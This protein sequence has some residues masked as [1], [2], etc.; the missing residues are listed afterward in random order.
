MAASSLPAG[1]RTAE[2]TPW[3]AVLRVLADGSAVGAGA[4]SYGYA[5]QG[6]AVSAAAGASGLRMLTAPGT[7]ITGVVSGGIGWQSSAVVT[8]DG[9][10]F[11]AGTAAYGGS[12]S[13]YLVEKALPAG[14]TAAAVVVR[15]LRM[16]VIM[17]DGS[18][19]ALGAN[20]SSAQGT[21]N[22]NNPGATLTPVVLPA[23]SVATDVEM[24]N[25]TTLFLLQSGAV[26][27]AGLN[28][29]GGAG[30]GTTGGAISTPVRVPLAHTATQIT[31]SWY[32]S[33]LAVL[34]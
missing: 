18:V 16:M 7:P 34:G 15:Q 32:D 27:F 26:Y 30:A 31:V 1:V 23:G 24:G 17:T 13:F 11:T 19:Y 2:V 10:L 12:G 25:D 8:G 20:T 9:R 6:S 29:T 22:A 14:K 3:G 4:D 28:D 5:A 21:G 33:F